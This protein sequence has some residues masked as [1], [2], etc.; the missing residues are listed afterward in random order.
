[1]S[2]SPFGEVPVF[3]EEWGESFMRAMRDYVT[4]LESSLDDDPENEVTEV[5]TISGLPFCGC[6]DCYERETYL[7][8]VKLAIEGYAAGKVRLA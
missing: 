5:E 4:T 7:M 1:M 2:S 6:S 8:A 3:D